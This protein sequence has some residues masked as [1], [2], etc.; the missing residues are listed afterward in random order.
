MNGQTVIT[1]YCAIRDGQVLVDGHIRHFRE[2]FTTFADFIRTL[3]KTEG[4]SYPKFFKM[5]AL[6]KLGF[7]TA[8]L[9]LKHKEIRE[10]DR[11]RTAMV[12]SNSSS[13]LDTD[14][15]FQKT[16]RDRNQYFPSPSVFV[17]TLPNILIGEVCIRHKIKGENAFLVSEHFDS[18]LLWRYVSELLEQKR[19]AGCIAGWVELLNDRFES[20]LA[21]IEIR[22]AKA[23]GAGRII[24][25]FSPEKLDELYRKI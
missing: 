16:I 14:L 6:S 12:V 13:S 20:L 18:L 2:N 10:A 9:L 8:E 15:A 4:I 1:G 11:D 23:D 17:Y 3:Y 21:F 5:D 25:P 24:G 7:M 22:D 19:A